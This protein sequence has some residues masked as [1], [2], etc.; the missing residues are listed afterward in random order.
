MIYEFRSYEAAPGRLQDLDRRFKEL[1]WPILE[2]L[3]F[4]QVGFWI[5]EESNRLVY[6]LRWKDR[7]ESE[8]KWK[9]FQ[10]DPEWQKGKADSEVNG[11]LLATLVTEFWSPTEYSTAS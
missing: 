9:E 8:A 5:P 11:P 1:T 7:A 2:R 6:L 4:E 10:A 3:G